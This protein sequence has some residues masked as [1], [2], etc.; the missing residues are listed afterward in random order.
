MKKALV[1]GANS[2]L[3]KAIIRRLHPSTE[4]SGVYHQ[5]ADNLVPEIRNIPVSQLA[6]LK[7]EYDVVFIISAY[8]PGK[9]ES[10]EQAEKLLQQVNVDLPAQICAQF[11][12]AN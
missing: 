12:K 11:A 2:F 6:Q 5:N 1:I 8:I 7:D 3:G 4:V 10:D 9:N